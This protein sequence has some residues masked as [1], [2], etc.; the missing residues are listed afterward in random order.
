MSRAQPASLV[1]KAAKA[2]GGTGSGFGDKVAI[3]R[4]P[5]GVKA[6][7]YARRHVGDFVMALLDTNFLSLGGLKIQRRRR[8]DELGIEAGADEYVM[9]PFDRDILEAKFML[10]PEALAEAG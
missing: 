9:K 5:P 8:A 3:L 4:V 2:A 7:A 6:L 10:E 1:L